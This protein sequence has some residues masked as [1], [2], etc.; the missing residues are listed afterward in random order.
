MVHIHLV[1]SLRSHGF[2]R[3]CQCKL[4]IFEQNLLCLQCLEFSHGCGTCSWPS[5]RQQIRWRHD[6]FDR[7]ATKWNN[8]MS[9][10]QS[11]V[12]ETIACRCFETSSTLWAI[13]GILFECWQCHTPAK[14][15]SPRGLK[16]IHIVSGLVF[17]LS[18]MFAAAAAAGYCTS[19]GTIA[20]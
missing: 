13:V 5:L 7:I 17:A 2:G 12:D 8:R 14:F 15:L 4:D 3:R 19:A 9:M 10:K 6:D 16:S 11:H 1:V 20:A 18:H